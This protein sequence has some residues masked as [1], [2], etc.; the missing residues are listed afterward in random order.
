MSSF[1][2]ILAAVLVVCW[3]LGF[4]FMEVGGSSIH[5][6]LLIALLAFLFGTVRRPTTA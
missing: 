4:F 5:F 3:V 1:F 2:Y 6:L